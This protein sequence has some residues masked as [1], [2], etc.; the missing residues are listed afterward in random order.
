MKT[1]KYFLIPC[2]LLLSLSKVMASSESNI[3]REYLFKIDRQIYSLSQKTNSI[4]RANRLRIIINSLTR[5]MA[6]KGLTFDAKIKKGRALSGTDLELL[7]RFITTY[8]NLMIQAQVGLVPIDQTE[9]SQ[10][11]L[12]YLHN[13][14]KMLQSLKTIH[15]AY[16]RPDAM[17]TQ[18]HNAFKKAEQS[19]TNRDEVLSLINN[20][21]SRNNQT[22]LRK[23][24]KDLVINGQSISNDG[25]ALVSLINRNSLSNEFHKSDYINIWTYTFFDGLASFGN[26][27]EYMLSTE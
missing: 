26:D 23:L 18:I 24:Y 27:V 7:Y 21:A 1:I 25:E 2:L 3:S 22:R 16:F 13:H 14:L 19:S 15:K 4:E 9:S 20:F 11:K 10:D 6:I 12:L 17:R 8:R 5:F